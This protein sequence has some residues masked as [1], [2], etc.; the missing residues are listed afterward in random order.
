[1]RTVVGYSRLYASI[2]KDCANRFLENLGNQTTKVIVI[3]TE[4][5]AKIRNKASSVEC[6]TLQKKEPIPKLLN[7]LATIP[8]IFQP[9][10]IAQPLDTLFTSCT[11]RV[12]DHKDDNL[13]D[14]FLL[15]GEG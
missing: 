15:D 13:S 8:F 3:A 1:M 10:Q 9:Y 11:N 6:H 2:C 14:I 4:K 12:I 7:T 5:S